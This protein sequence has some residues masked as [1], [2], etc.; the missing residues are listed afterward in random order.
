VGAGLA[1]V[2][3]LIGW[4]FI[5]SDKTRWLLHGRARY[6]DDLEMKRVGLHKMT[7]TDSV[8]AGTGCYLSR[9]AAWYLVVTIL[10]SNTW[11]DSLFWG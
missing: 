2:Y 1:K 3:H 4:M 9:Q 8:P 7:E 5:A 6:G 10:G 11:Q